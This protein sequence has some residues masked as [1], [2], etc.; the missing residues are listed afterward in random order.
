M[1]WPMYTRR[2]KCSAA[3]SEIGPISVTYGDTFKAMGE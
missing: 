2:G 1:F 3:Y